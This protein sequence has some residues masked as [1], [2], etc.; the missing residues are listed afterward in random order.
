VDKE[1]LILLADT[2][3]YY[4]KENGRNQAHHISDLPAEKL[5]IPS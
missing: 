1:K 2:A 4:A 5:R 3:M